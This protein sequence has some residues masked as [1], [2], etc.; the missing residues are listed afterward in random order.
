MWNE[1]P[2]GVI[3]GGAASQYT[4]V[5]TIVIYMP[6]RKWLLG[7]LL[8]SRTFKSSVFAFMNS[9]C[10][11]TVGGTNSNLYFIALSSISN[12]N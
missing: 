3:A 4:S 8:Q 5:F 7:K 9:S 11:M 6:D 12:R 1:N 2:D 10:V